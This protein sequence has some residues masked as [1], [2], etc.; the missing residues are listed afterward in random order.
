MKTTY[1]K[2]NSSIGKASSEQRVIIC[3][4]TIH[5]CQYTSGN[6]RRITVIM[7][8]LHLTFYLGTKVFA[9]SL[10]QNEAQEA[11]RHSVANAGGSA[12][13]NL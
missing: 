12:F 11:D 9:T 3:H 2:S 5:R 8:V 10:P 7:S 1:Q 13:G 6:A 4:N